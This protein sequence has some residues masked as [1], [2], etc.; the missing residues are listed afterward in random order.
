[1]KEVRTQRERAR[2][3]SLA[4]EYGEKGYDVT[5]NP[6]PHELPASLRRFMP[7]LIVRGKDETILVEVKTRSTLSAAKYLK[8][9][10]EAVEQIP[11]WRFELVITNPK[12]R[13]VVFEKTRL[14]TSAA[15]F[16]RLSQAE[17]FADSGDLEAAMLLAWS[18]AEGLLRRIGEREGV[19]L[20]D[21]GSSYVIKKLY[22]IGLLTKGSYKLFERGIKARNQLVHGFSVRHLNKTFVKRL[23]RELR[24]TAQKN[25]K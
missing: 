2:I 4:R 15:L 13:P 19:T 16:K 5:I 25:L 8:P 18:A 22:S 9:L 23:V 11:G 12:G 14:P 17:R 10:A 24:R 21:R 7:D 20:E 1:M 3:E 6:S